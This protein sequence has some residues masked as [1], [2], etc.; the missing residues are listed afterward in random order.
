MVRVW[1]DQWSGSELTRAKK[2]RSELT[3]AESS[4]V[5]IDHIPA[6]LTINGNTVSDQTVTDILNEQMKYCQKLYE[7]QNHLESI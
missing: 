4:E 3:R 6:Q 5:R 2:L 7:K 1:T